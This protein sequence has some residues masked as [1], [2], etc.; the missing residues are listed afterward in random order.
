MVSYETSNITDTSWFN[1]IN[2][3]HT[4][5]ICS[6]VLDENEKNYAKM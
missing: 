3:D 6:D 5:P 2:N 4:C 1:D